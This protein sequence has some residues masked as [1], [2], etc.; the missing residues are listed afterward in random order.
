M[1]D[2]VSKGVTLI[3]VSSSFTRGETAGLSF[4]VLN[5][6]GDILVPFSGE[7]SFTISSNH[8]YLN[9]LAPLMRIFVI[10]EAACH[11]L[12]TSPLFL[13]DLLQIAT[14]ATMVFVFEN[15]EKTTC[16]QCMG[17]VR[18]EYY[19]EAANVS[20]RTTNSAVFVSAFLD[21]D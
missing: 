14:A 10:H 8:I 15:K 17:I 3:Y 16:F 11:Q 13:L 12:G 9:I 4:R 21:E 5:S 2:D 18:Q 6:L 19:R 20:L 7:Y 1:V